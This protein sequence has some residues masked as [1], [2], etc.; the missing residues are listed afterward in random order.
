MTAKHEERHHSMTPWP[1]HGGQL[2]TLA[3]R[4]PQA[5]T[6]LI[7]LSTGINPF[8]YPFTPPGADALSRLPDPAEEEA[9]RLAASQ[10]YGVSPDHVLAGPGTQM[11]IGL[12]PVLLSRLQRVEGVR[13]LTP[14]Y[15]G[16]ETAWAA[17]G[18]PITFI[19][20]GASLPMPGSNIVTIICAP[21]NPTGHV[22]SA[23]EIASLAE[24]HGHAGGVLVIDEAFADFQPVSAVSLLPHRALIVCRSFGKTYGLAGVRLGFLLGTHP[25]LQAMREV[26]GPWAVN[27]AG[28]QIGR[29]ALL[30]TAWRDSMRLHLTH[31][32]QILRHILH[33]AGLSFV[34]GTLLF[35][36]WRTAHAQEIWERLAQAG[37]LVRRFAWDETLLRFGL[38]ADEA[39][40]T[41]LTEALASPAS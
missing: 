32:T 41:R 1:A 35:S 12:L 24:S 18:V 20:H 4:F 26:M 38:P 6:P 10:A 22:L 34:G 3:H 15:S 5:P 9:L 40:L 21:N 19:P 11:L 39:A 17:A 37:I 14:T 29:E 16:H 13:I 31:Q 8:A 28:C 23:E 2:S 30:D 36:L 25:V 33:D 7:D 27:T